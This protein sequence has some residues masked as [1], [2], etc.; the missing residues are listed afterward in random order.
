MNRANL[1]KAIALAGIALLGIHTAGA[2]T[3]QRFT[4]S[5]LAK[6]SDSIVLARVEDQSSR[7]EAGTKEIYTYITLRVLEPVKGMKAEAAKKGASSDATI[8]IRQLGGTVGHYMSIV[9]GMPSFKN[10]EE[11]VLFLTPKD[12]AGYP[13]VVGLQ[14]G[15]YTVTTDANGMK[16]VRNDVDGLRVLSPNGTVNEAKVSSEQPLNAFLDGI[17]TQLDLPGKVQV[18]P[19]QPTE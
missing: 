7:M 14:Q 1:A 12:R 13:W 10:G 6:K 4:L 8:T 16:H 19:T 18:D 5:D 2:T 11:V 9:P 17:K 15:K 3:V